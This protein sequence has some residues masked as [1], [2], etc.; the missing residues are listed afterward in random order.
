MKPTTYTSKINEQYG[1][2]NLEKK[3]EAALEAAGKNLASLTLEDLASLENIHLGGRDAS[4]KLARSADL[5][6]GNKVLDVGCGL[7]GPARMLAVEF[8]CQVI[9]LD[10]AEDFCQVAEI[11]TEAVGLTPQV[12]FRQGDALDM[13]FDDD[14]FDGI[15]SQHC[16]M[17]IADK[18]RLYSEFR[19]VLKKGGT[20]MIHDILAGPVQP[21]QYPV[22]WARD[23][24]IS[25]LLTAE[26][27]RELLV[28]TGFIE[29]HWQEVS[30]EAIQW[31]ERQKAAAAGNKAPILNQFLVFGDD[32]RPMVGNMK[33]NLRES[34]IQVVEVVGTR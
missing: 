4:L 10:L 13:P 17:N 30:Q 1:R 15:W 33:K 27:L 26:E 16:A 12:G 22:V 11:L 18:K 29:H 31:F 34:R 7:G 19:R 28:E 20:L 5:Q 21:V 32:L 2:R 8:G 14:T 3:I 23:P 24:S 9:G 25:F 6:E